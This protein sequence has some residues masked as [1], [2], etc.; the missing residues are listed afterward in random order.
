MRNPKLAH[1]LVLIF[2]GPKPTT[3]KRSYVIVIVSSFL[4]MTVSQ[5]GSWICHNSVVNVSWRGPRCLKLGGLS[6]TVLNNKKR[7]EKKN[8]LYIRCRA[9]IISAV[10]CDGIFRCLM[11]SAFFQHPRN[12]VSFVA[13]SDRLLH[14][15]HLLELNQKRYNLQQSPMT[16]GYLIMLAGM[17]AHTSSWGLQA[18][19]TSKMFMLCGVCVVWIQIYIPK[20]LKYPFSNM[21]TLTYISKSC[22]YIATNPDMSVHVRETDI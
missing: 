18:T 1:I 17:M 14:E 13:I 8:S 10:S 3:S 5:I 19:C 6:R 9:A 20:I 11:W 15:S 21:S 4:W 12:C 16:R 7:K 22:K 2:F